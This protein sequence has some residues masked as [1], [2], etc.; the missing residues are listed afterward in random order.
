VRFVFRL[1]LMSCIALAVGFGLSY[2]ALTDGRLFSVSQ[3]GPWTAWPDVGS[4]TPNPYTRAHL[5]REAA[6]QLGQAEGLRFVATLDSQGE[7]LSRACSYLVAGRTPQANFWTLVANDAAGTNVAV[8]DGPLALRS[9]GVAREN[10]GSLRIHVGTSL[11][12]GNWLELAGDG[13]FSLVLTLYDTAVFT[14]FG[15]VGDTMPAIEREAC[16]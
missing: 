2:F 7:P 4:P 16:R 12:P 8:P 15:A 1:L 9:T 6:L 5:T 14:G 10:D 13:P 3:L 11:S